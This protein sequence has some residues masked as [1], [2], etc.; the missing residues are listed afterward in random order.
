MAAF[1]Q[2]CAVLGIVDVPGFV[3]RAGTLTF[4][5]KKKSPLLYRVFSTSKLL[6]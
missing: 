2:S 6:R 5:F 3:L 1:Q 4:Y